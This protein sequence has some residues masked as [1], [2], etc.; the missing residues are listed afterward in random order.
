MSCP[1]ATGDCYIRHVQRRHKPTPH[2][3]LSLH[4]GA[5]E[6]HLKRHK[7]S[8]APLY[9]KRIKVKTAKKPEQPVL[10]SNRSNQSWSI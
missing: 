6:R 4:P 8:T 3:N 1:V 9:N 2:D 7:K 10:S 5:P